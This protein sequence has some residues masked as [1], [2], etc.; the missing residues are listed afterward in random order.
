MRINANQQVLM[1][2]VQAAATTQQKEAE[3][4]REVEQRRI[5]L[6]TEKLRAREMSKAQVQAEATAKA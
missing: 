1:A 6:E 4:Q 3:L 2:R 5:A